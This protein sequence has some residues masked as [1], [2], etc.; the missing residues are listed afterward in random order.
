MYGLSVCVH[1]QEFHER[2]EKETT[3]MYMCIVLT[4]NS[5]ESCRWLVVFLNF[6]I[7]I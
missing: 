3:S 5:V 7:E 1:T 4:R 2:D 6:D